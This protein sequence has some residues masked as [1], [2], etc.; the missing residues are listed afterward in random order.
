MIVEIKC[1]SQIIALRYE[2]D[3]HYIKNFIKKPKVLLQPFI[4]SVLVSSHCIANYHKMRG[5]KQHSFIASQFLTSEVQV[6][7]HRV[8]FSSFHTEN[9]CQAEIYS[10]DSGKDSTPK[11][12][13]WLS[14][15]S[16]LWL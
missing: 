16:S 4:P 10:G 6:Q 8:F 5:L 14:E 12:F 2:Q 15:L 7:V 3:Q 9:V 11:S 13:M 1:N